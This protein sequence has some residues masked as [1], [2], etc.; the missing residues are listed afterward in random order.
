M[1]KRYIIC[2]L[3]ILFSWLG[4]PLACASEN[5]ALLIGIDDYSLSPGFSNLSG[6]PN[7]IKIMEAALENKGFALDHITILSNAGATHSRIEKAFK[8]L[9]ARIRGK[10]A[11]AVYI[12][13]SGHGSQTRDLNGDEKQ[14]QDLQGNPLPSYDQTWVT[15]GS[16]LAGGTAPPPDFLDIDAYDILD[17]ELSQW[18]DEIAL[19][20]D[21]VVFV[22]DSCHSGSVSRCGISG[23]LRRGPADHR[24]HP[25]GRNK[26]RQRS[27]NNVIRIG[28]SKD[29]QPAKEFLPARSNERYGVFTWYWVQA[30]KKCRPGD[31]WMHV[32]NRVSHIIY[33]ETP[34]RQTPVISG[35]VTMKIFG[36]DFLEPAQTI[37]VYQ[38]LNKAGK[39]LVYLRA[40]RLSGVTEG[41]TYTLEDKAGHPDAPEIRIVRVEADRSMAVSRAAVRVNDQAVEV[42]HHHEF[43]ATRLLL[44]VAHKKDAGAPLDNIRRTIGELEP[45]QVTGDD[46]ACDL[47]IYLFRPDRTLTSVAGPGDGSNNR[48][49]PPRSNE[50]AE[51]QIWILD[52][53]G[54]LYQD[55]LRHA[56]TPDGLAALKRNLLRLARIRDFLELN[57]PGRSSPLQI[58]VTPMVPALLTQDTGPGLVPNEWPTDT[59]PAEAYRPLAPK[60]LGDFL[61]RKWDLCTMLRFHIKNPTAR[62][63]YFYFVYIGNDFE[64]T[65]VFPSLQDGSQLAEVE[66][67]T[68]NNGGNAW[69]RFDTHTLERFKIIICEKPINHRLFY[70][71]GVQLALRGLKNSNQLDPLER[72]LWNA[73]TGTRSEVSYQAGDWYAETITIDMR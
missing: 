9:A 33:R 53:N 23:G 11:G 40:G 34:N 46:Q 41:S 7:D 16:R 17:D 51:P 6:P 4:A 50:N 59:C 18:L 35:A 29:D 13:Y 20:C 54:F 30:L 69:V 14:I 5:Y 52:K 45:Y 57:N 26:Y 55:K 31:S 64:I 72:I 3:L 25:L 27:P 15:Y 8:T 66:P 24:E 48:S 12:Y 19:G 67:G 60:S 49:A 38:V 71:A 21:Q 1:R 73:A 61:G 63:Y 39:Y 28:A 10:K 47:I 37:P 22:S 32:F 68:Q 43:P 36:S 2:S 70:Q 44:K 62:K 65:P 56:C 58:T 42:W